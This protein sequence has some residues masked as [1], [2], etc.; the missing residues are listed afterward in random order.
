MVS[1]KTLSKKMSDVTIFTFLTF[2]TN[3]DNIKFVS[4]YED[5]L[6]SDGF[7]EYSKGYRP[8]FWINYKWRLLSSK[9]LKI[10]KKIYE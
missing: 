6:P 3:F 4:M 5:Q 10:K 7:S 2:D 8:R 9:F 1:N